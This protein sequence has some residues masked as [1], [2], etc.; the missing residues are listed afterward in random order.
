MLSMG[1]IPITNGDPPKGSRQQ[2]TTVPCS[3]SIRET[4]SRRSADELSRRQSEASNPFVFG[5]ALR[6][7]RLRLAA[8]FV[9]MLNTVYK[10]GVRH[11]KLIKQVP[12]PKDRRYN[13]VPMFLSIAP[14]RKH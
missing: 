3:F 2:P 4:T 6:D 11:V 8:G 1:R 9:G 7:A 5:V 14:L 13:C 12:D 10:F